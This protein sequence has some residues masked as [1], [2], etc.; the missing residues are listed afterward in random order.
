MK[1]VYN[2]ADCGALGHLKKFDMFICNDDQPRCTKCCIIAQVKVASINSPR[3]SGG[4][5][6]MESLLEVMIESRKSPRV[7]SSWVE[8]GDLWFTMAIKRSPETKRLDTQPTQPAQKDEDGEE[9]A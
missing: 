4:V 9:K 2:C 6:T 7:H 3:P 8:K 1:F 5:Y